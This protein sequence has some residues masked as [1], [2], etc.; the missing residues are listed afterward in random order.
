MGVDNLN[1]KY[2]LLL[3]SQISE[4]ILCDV[5]FFF[6]LFFSNLESLVYH[7]RY[8]TS[9]TYVFSIRYHDSLYKFNLPCK[10]FMLNIVKV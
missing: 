9:F 7:R 6:L 3:D 8:K 2:S 5:F 4:Y 10:L 1:G